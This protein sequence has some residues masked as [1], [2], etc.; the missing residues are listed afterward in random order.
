MIAF[1]GISVR[2]GG[3]TALD[4]VTEEVAEGELCVLVGPSGSGKSTLL[5]LVNRL[6]EPTEGAVRV[7]GVDVRAV[8]AARL[9]RSIG[10]VIQSV[11]LFPHRTV[12]RNV[13]TVPRLLGWP[14]ARIEARV[15][16]MLALVR[17]DPAE[18]AS[19]RPRELSG[20]Q[21]QRV[22][23]ARALAADPDILLMDEPFGAVD[24]IARR[25]LRAELRRIHAATGKTILLVTHDPGEAIELASR[26]VVL[27]DG[28]VVA[29]GGPS[30]VLG[31][32]GAFV[33]ALLGGDAALRAL[34]LVPARRLAEPDPAPDAPALAADATLQDALSLMIESRRTRVRLPAAESGAEASLS[35]ARLVERRP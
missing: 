9:R 2:F 18:F 27:R 21:A 34:S 16:E 1:D 28:R 12:A 26:L 22:G 17:L 35:L 30:E 3:A 15:R 4:G 25:D 29:S 32:G 6:V 33:R 10:Y 24:P 11:G 13:A 7:R 5:R 20:G 14:E 31:G 19:R 23:I 8:E